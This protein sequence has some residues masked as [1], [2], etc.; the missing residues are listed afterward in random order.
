MRTSPSPSR[1]ARLALL[2]LLALAVVRIGLTY[3]TYAPTV[4]E[5]AHIGPG[6]EWLDRGTYT[7]DPTHPPLARAMQAVGA[8]LMGQRSGELAN[9]WTEGDYVIWSASSPTRVVTLAR[10]AVLP[11]F[12]AFVIVVWVWTRSLFGTRAAVGAAFVAT[13]LPPILAHAG[14]AT[15]DM[16]AAA[17]VMLAALAW[18]RWLEGPTRGRSAALGAAIGIALISKLSALLFLPAVF[19]ALWLVRTIGRSVSV[20]TVAAQGAVAA[21]VAGLVLW[22]GYRFQLAPLSGP[23]ERPH[24]ALDERF[25]TSGWKHDL[26]Y[27]VVEVPVPARDYFI[28][29]LS[30]AGHN[31][32]GLRSYLLGDARFGGRW[33]FFP[34]AFLVKT[35]IPVLLLFAVGAVWAVRSR[36]EGAAWERWAPL[37]GAATVMACV[38]PSGI[39]IGLRHVLP[40]YGFVAILAGAGAAALLQAPRRRWIGAAAAA[41]LLGW[42]A[43]DSVA[44]HPDYLAYFNEAARGRADRVLV[45]SDLD[46][47]QDVKRL[48]DTLRARGITHV[49]L[50]ARHTLPVRFEKFGFPAH[51]FL[52]P[53]TPDTGWVAADVFTLRLG[54][55][56]SKPI[57]GYWWLNDL[58]PDARIGKSMRLYYVTDSAARAA[59]AAL[60]TR[61]GEAAGRPAGAPTPPPAPGS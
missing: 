60:E 34:V 42:L 53:Y 32:R 58:T 29:V 17:T 15:T 45:D 49:S 38:L 61:R 48:R 14:L 33:Y 3:R 24:T 4:D 56:G 31:A 57:D 50:A 1:G 13:M 7:L 19:G 6:L 46:W 52:E 2:V 43:V 47:G 41:V 5:P 44:A 39:N 27:A 37:A 28:G 26:A 22:A 54:G 20:R 30:L 8:Y 11:F 35:P 10:L 9:Q 23:E 51:R 59:A 16:A 25:G 12:I 40:I 18:V 21:V 36:R 55:V